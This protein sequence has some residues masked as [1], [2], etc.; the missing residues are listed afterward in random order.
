[1]EKIKIGAIYGRSLVIVIQVIKFLINGSDLRRWR[2]THCDYRHGNRAELIGK[3]FGN[4]LV[5]DFYFNV[6]TKESLWKLL[7]NCGE[8]TTASINHLT[9][10]SKKVMWMHK[11]PKFSWGKVWNVIVVGD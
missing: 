3:V 10:G 5:V 1:M 7:C 2:K 6:E 8:L 11:L 9:S 4:L